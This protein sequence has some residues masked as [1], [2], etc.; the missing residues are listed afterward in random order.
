[1]QRLLC[2][3]TIVFVLAS[4]RSP[5]ELTSHQR[6]GD[7]IIDGNAVEWDGKTMVLREHQATLGVQHDDEFL[8]LCFTTSDRQAQFQI[9]G[10]GLTVWFDP[11]G[12][13]KKSFGVHFPMGMEA[14]LRMLPRTGQP[15]IDVLGIALQR[16]RPEME[17]LGPGKDER[18]RVTIGQVGGINARLGRQQ[19]LLIYELKV[20][21]KFSPDHPWSI[22]VVPTNALSI[23]LEAEPLSV[24]RLPSQRTN[25]PTAGRGRGRGSG[26]NIQGPGDQPEPLKIWARV[27]WTPQASPQE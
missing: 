11:E 13:E 18:R 16:I 22:E 25:V 12:K 27:H 2:I 1:M 26:G 14:P 15:D 8:Y 10:R 17:L 6:T 20:P 3:A 21:L 9:L 5:F 24:E 7:I 23:G 19:D 4:C